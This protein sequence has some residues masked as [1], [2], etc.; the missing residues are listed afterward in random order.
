MVVHLV[1]LMGFQ[2][3][4]GKVEMKVMMVYSLVEMMVEKLDQSWVEMMAVK[5]VEKVEKMVVH[6]VDSM[7]F[8]TVEGKV[9]MKV[10]TVYS[11]VELM[12]VTK[13]SKSVE[14]TVHPKAYYLVGSLVVDL[15]EMME[16]MDLTTVVQ[17]VPSK[18]L[19]LAAL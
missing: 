18:A 14:Q 1:D 16:K 12:A 10:M 2:T 7:G 9:E 19:R 11:L 3:V 8:Q 15:V 4:E 13:D 17:K 5:M 6:L